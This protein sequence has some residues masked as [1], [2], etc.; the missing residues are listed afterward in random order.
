MVRVDGH[1]HRETSCWIHHHGERAIGAIWPV[2]VNRGSGAAVRF[3]AATANFNVLENR[4]RVEGAPRDVEGAYNKLN[5]I[6]GLGFFLVSPRL[7][8]TTWRPERTQYLP[9]SNHKPATGEGGLYLSLSPSRSRT[10]I[11]C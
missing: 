7:D 1:R 11:I 4:Y 8:V 2:F 6:K 3:V 5:C 10:R 9:L